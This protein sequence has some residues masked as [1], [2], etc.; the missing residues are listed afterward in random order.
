MCVYV[1]SGKRERERERWGGR[2]CSSLEGGRDKGS[3]CKGE[4]ARKEENVL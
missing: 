3:A 2:V 1:L 4:G